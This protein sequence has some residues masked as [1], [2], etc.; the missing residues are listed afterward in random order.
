MERSGRR[1]TTEDTPIRREGAREPSAG[2][3]TSLAR[4]LGGPFGSAMAHALVV[5]PTAPTQRNRAQRA[6]RSAV[7]SGL[8]SDSVWLAHRPGRRTGLSPWS[9]GSYQVTSVRPAGARL[10]VGPSRQ[11]SDRAGSQS[12]TEGLT[13]PRPPQARTSVTT[14]SCGVPEDGLGIT[15][16][17]TV[18]H[19]LP[20]DPPTRVPPTP[21]PHPPSCES[22]L[23]GN[24][25]PMA[26]GRHSG[27]AAPR[28]ASARGSS[29]G[30]SPL[31]RSPRFLR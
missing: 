4:P 25:S 3:L 6:T 11:I 10:R 18:V 21:S 8:P 22:H 14:R 16:R 12:L 7:P 19:P 17:S 29:S 1:S 30:L 9:Q 26:G 13:Q 15:A 20:P 28:R 24:V 31:A 27:T 23:G 5:S 2:G